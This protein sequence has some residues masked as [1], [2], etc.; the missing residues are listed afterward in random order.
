MELLEE[1]LH[2]LEERRA[3]RTALPLGR[4]FE[5][6][7]RLALAGAE[8]VGNLED[9][10]VATV[11]VAATAEVGHALAAQFQQV[12]RL[13]SG[14]DLELRRPVEHGHVDLGAE[15]ELRKGQGQVAVEIGALAGEQLVVE[16]P[17]EDVQVAGRAPEEPARALAVEPHLHS[18]LDAGGDLDLEHALG[19][20]ST[21]SAA[22]LARRLDPLAL[23]P[24]LRARS[25]D[26][27]RAQLGGDLTPPATQV[28][29]DRTASRLGSAARAVLAGL[30]ARDLHLGLDAAR[31]V[32][33][34]DLQLVLEGLGQHRT[35][36]PTT[37]AAPAR[38]EV[39]EDVLEE[40]A[41]AGLSESAA[42][43]S[44]RAEAVIVRALVGIGEH[45]VCLVD[46][47]E[48]LLGLLVTGIAVGMVLHRE[49]AVRLLDLRLPS[50]ARNPQHLVEIA[51][52]LAGYAAAEKRHRPMKRV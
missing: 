38:E 7:Q 23:T 40:R 25:P 29:H 8:R 1:L 13:A 28:A 26:R 6:L 4:G 14:R 41:E 46:G 36:V 20:L 24:A 42:R 31:R 45:R 49:L 15:R 47:L 9:Q 33:E 2:P 39:L 48:A 18:V 32:F 51:R 44:D 52:H 3:Q 21:L 30:E 37:A 27:Q 11:S 17:D 10:A 5:G 12:M 34:R 43:R 22:D 35:G 16:D 19:P 50:P